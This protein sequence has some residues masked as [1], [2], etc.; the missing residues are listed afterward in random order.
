MKISVEKSKTMVMTRGKKEGKGIIKTGDVD[1]EI[2][3]HFKYLGSEL[4]EN[5]RL[6]MQCLLPSG[7]EFNLG[8]R[9]T[10]EG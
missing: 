9:H 10:V 5:A 7:S 3:E 2:V 4:M 1:L 6:D 8:Q